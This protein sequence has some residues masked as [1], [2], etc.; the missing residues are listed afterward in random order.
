[1]RGILGLVIGGL[2]VAGALTGHLVLVSKSPQGWL[3]L[4]AV[5]GMLILLGL[6]R[7]TARKRNA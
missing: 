7:L 4:P 1:M 5:G 3:F 2:V 6:Y